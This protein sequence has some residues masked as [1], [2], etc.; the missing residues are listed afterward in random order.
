MAQGT[1]RCVLRNGPGPAT[2]V[3]WLTCVHKARGGAPQEQPHSQHAHSGHCRKLYSTSS[4]RAQAPVGCPNVE[5]GLKFKP[6]PRGLGSR[7][8][9]CVSQQGCDNHREKRRP[10]L[11][12]SA[13][14]GHHN[15]YV[16]YKG[17]MVNTLC[18]DVAG[19]YAKNSS[20]TKNIRL[21][22]ATQGYSHIKI[23]LQDLQYTTIS[24]KLR[25]TEI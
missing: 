9:I 13:S 18:K 7:T 23:A 20:P 21:M 6:I 22:E 12:S 16:A 25:V 4:G 11:T 17:L 24:P 1:T 10:C 8:D 5:V 3:P 14:S 15:N 19:I 2:E